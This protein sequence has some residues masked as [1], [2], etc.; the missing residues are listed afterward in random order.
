M[1]KVRGRDELFTHRD[2][3]TLLKVAE[4]RPNPLMQIRAGRAV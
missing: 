4:P 2:R 1:L 3:N